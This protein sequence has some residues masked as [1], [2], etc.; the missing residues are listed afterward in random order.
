MMKMVITLKEESNGNVSIDMAPDNRTGTPKEFYVSRIVNKH[1]EIASGNI[2]KEL[3][4]GIMVE[5]DNVAKL[6]DALSRKGT[7]NDN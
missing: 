5:G 1:L 2:L 6:K 7:T 3:G 4:G